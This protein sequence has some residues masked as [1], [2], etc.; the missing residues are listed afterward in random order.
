MMCSVVHRASLF[1]V[2]MYNDRL[3]LVDVPEGILCTRVRFPPS[4]PF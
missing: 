2:R 1:K 4:P 3:H